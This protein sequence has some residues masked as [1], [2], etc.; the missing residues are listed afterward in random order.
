MM[1]QHMSL[2]VLDELGHLAWSPLSR[3]HFDNSH[4]PGRCGCL[5]A[6]SR[7]AARASSCRTKRSRSAAPTCRPISTSNS[8]AAQ[9]WTCSRRSPMLKRFVSESAERAAG[10]EMALDV[11]RVLDCSMD[12]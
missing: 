5:T 11:E 8:K 10:N 3:R 7:P 6:L 12:G 1:A 4:M 9:P 2:M